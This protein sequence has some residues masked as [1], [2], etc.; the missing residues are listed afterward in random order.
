MN[1]AYYEPR[2][3]SRTI[4]ESAG[5]LVARIHPRHATLK[6]LGNL[7]QSFRGEGGQLLPLDVSPAFAP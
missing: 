1:L 6:R 3:L 2:I 5:K 4:E 7:A